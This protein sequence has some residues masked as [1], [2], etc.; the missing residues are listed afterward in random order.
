MARK[1]TARMF[2]SRI[3]VGIWTGLA[4]FTTATIVFATIPGSGGIIQGCYATSSGDLRI[5]DGA[6]DACRANETAISW[7]QSGIVGYELMSTQ[8][9]V[10]PYNASVVTRANYTPG[11]RVLG[12]GYHS[13]NV[14][15]IQSFPQVSGASAGWQVYAQNAGWQPGSVTAYAICA[16]ARP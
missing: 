10:V 15:I 4:V 3:A 16:M 2:G 7:S 5:I 1:L 12:G 6:I 8:T 9:V 14:Q 13:N 11:K